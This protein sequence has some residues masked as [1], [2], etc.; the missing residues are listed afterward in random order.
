MTPELM[1]GSDWDGENVSGWWASEKLNG[2]RCVWD[3]RRF[4]TRQ[5]L[6]YKAPAW[7]GEGMPDQPLDGELWAGPRTTHD[8]VNAAVRSGRWEGLTYRPFDVPALGVTVE[9]AQAILATLALPAHV[10]PVEYRR[11]GSTA[12]A[13][14]T[15]RRIIQAGG[16]GVMLRRPN[17][18]YFT[19]RRTVALLKLKGDA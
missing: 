10:Q 3:G 5:G 12:E 14:A 7:F 16:E 17:S 9:A 6:E 4:L 19:E 15:M 2:W 1:H 18:K 11:V 8:D 13:L